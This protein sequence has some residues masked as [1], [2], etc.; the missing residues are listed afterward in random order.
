MTHTLPRFP[1]KVNNLQFG[2]P[3]ALKGS[4]GW[5]MTTK[6]AEFIQSKQ[7]E[8]QELYLR[9]Q[10]LNE[11]IDLLEAAEEYEDALQCCEHC[12]EYVVG[13]H[14]TEDSDGWIVPT[15]KPPVKDDGCVFCETGLGTV[16]L[17]HEPHFRR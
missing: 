10:Y 6:T 9:I 13:N 17:T 14:D 12:L 4:G 16:G 2:T 7:D 11:S 3:L 5:H 15:G 8:I 1:C